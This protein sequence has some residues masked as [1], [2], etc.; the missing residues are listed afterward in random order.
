VREQIKSLWKLQRL[1]LELSGLESRKQAIPQEIQQ[2][3]Q[4]LKAEEEKYQKRQAEHE[5]FSSRRRS[6][7]QDVEEARDKIKRFKSQLLQIKTNKEYQT[8]L[9]EI[10][11]ENT[12]IAAYEEESLETLNKSDQLSEDLEKISGE[13]KNQQEEFKK[14]EKKVQE[15]LLRVNTALSAKKEEAEQVASKVNR[16][17]LARYRQIREGR[18][19]VGIV[20]VSKSACTGCNAVIPP[21]FIAEIIQ[22]DHVLTCEQCGR[23][24]VWK[25]NVD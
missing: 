22:G 11:V 8:L 16:A 15:E 12:K 3:K 17:P 7:E 24:L 14:F 2:T 25:E 6:L 18:G 21:Q 9:H 20:A 10:S 13:L 5:E 4:Q 23:I 19:G 1:D